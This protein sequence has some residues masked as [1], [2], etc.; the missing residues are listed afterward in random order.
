MQYRKAACLSILIIL[1]SA[2][3]EKISDTASA[4][5]KNGEEIKAPHPA[6]EGMVWIPGG[7]FTMGAPESDQRAWP[8]EK[9]AHPVRVD[10]FFM[11]RTEVT[12]DEFAEFVRA[13]GYTTVAERPV[14]WE[15]LKTQVPPG[16]PKPQDSLLQPGSLVFEIPDDPNPNE[17]NYFQWWKWQTGANWKNPQGPGSSIEGKGKHPVVHIA[18]ED[19]LAYCEWKGRRLP[20]EAEWE[21]AAR[22]GLTDRTFS[23]GDEREKLEEN[24]NTWTGPFPEEETLEDGYSRLAP[25]ASYPPNGFGL[26]DMAG[27]VWEWTTDW[28]SSDYYLQARKKGELVNPK[29]PEEYNNPSNPYTAQK[30]TKGG[31]FLCSDSYCASYRATARMGTDIDSG[32][33]HLGFRTVIDPK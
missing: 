11:D 23:W 20:T 31:S 18:F 27:N 3:K 17:M 33:E 15:V 1:F 4:T 30:V 9:P 16:T 6:P 21:F 5:V 24:A 7:N 8:H 2:C 13:T 12:N 25:V 26:H 14:D 22:G 19:A 10:G 32:Q 28:Y 29:G